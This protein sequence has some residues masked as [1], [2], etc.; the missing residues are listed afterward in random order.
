MNLKNKIKHVKKK[1]NMGSSRLYDVK[2][3]MTED[4]NAKCV[5]CLTPKIKKKGFMSEETLDN[6]IKFCAQQQ[7]WINQFHFYSIGESTLHPVF[8]ELLHSG[9]KRLSPMGIATVLTTNACSPNFPIIDYTCLDH[10]VISLNGFNKESYEKTTGLKW[11]T[12]INNIRAYFLENK[13]AKKTEIHILNFQGDVKSAMSD[14]IKKIK[15]DFEVGVRVSD[16]IDNQCGELDVD[17]DEK[18]VACNYVS[19]TY[20]FDSWGEMLICAHDFFSKHSYGNINTDNRDAILQKKHLEY[21][22]H[23]WEERDQA[24]FEGEDRFNHPLCA[25]C[26]FN[27]EEEGHFWFL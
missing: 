7:K 15:S 24:L 17:R 22:H 13:T 26:N 9:C 16:K 21:L 5:S 3:N 10:M 27:V 23:R 4:C 14:E 25:K 12:A 19:S 11:E 6:I 8:E 2:I 18:R 20:I 1:L